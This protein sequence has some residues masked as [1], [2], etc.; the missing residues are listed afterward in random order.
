M[1]TFMKDLPL[2]KVTVDFG[3]GPK[4]VY[5]RKKASI[6]EAMAIEKARER[7]GRF[8]VVAETVLVRARNSE[9]SLLFQDSD[10]DQLIKQYDP[11][12][13]ADVFMAMVDKEEPAGN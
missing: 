3:G 10:R 7:G 6:F 5:F 4:D 1:G 9:G 12:S 8:D 11:D 2:S 13:V